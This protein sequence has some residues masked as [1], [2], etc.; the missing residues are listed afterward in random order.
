MSEKPLF[1]QSNP[2]SHTFVTA[3]NSGPEYTKMK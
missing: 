1:K 2:I 3:I